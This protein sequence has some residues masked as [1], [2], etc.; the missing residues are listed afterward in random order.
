VTTE[1][2]TVLFTDMVGSTALASSLA[3]D[4]ADE[5]RR[6]HFAILRQAVAESG[7]IEV[8]HLGDGLMVVF[9]TA[10]A[11]LSCAVGMQQGVERDNRAREHLVGLRVGL[12][13]GEVIREDDDYFGDPVV[14]ASRLCARGES[15]QVL[16]ADVVRLMA[17]RRSRHECRVLGEVN[18][19]GLPVP[20]A[21]VE[22]V[23]EPLGAADAGTSVPLP[24][25]LAVRPAVGV[26]GRASEITVMLDA[27][28]R[29]ANGEGREV[30]LVSGEP[31]LG[32]STLVAEV[33][34]SGFDAGTCV[35][36][37]HCEEDL[38]SPYQLFGEALG[39]YV[40]H[41]AEDQLVAHV[42]AHGS[43]LVRLVPVLATRI[44]GLPPSMA[45]DADSERF[46]LFAAVVGIL[47]AASERQPVVL[48]LDDLQWADT[49]SLQL[50]RHLI[51][52]DL[53]MR[54]LILGAYR[55][56]ELSHSH[57]L[58]DTLAALHRQPAVTRIELAGLDDG[59]VVAFL[60]AAAGHVLD[61]AGLGLAHAVY[62]ETDGNPFFVSEVLRH[63][64]ETGAI[65]QDTAT[66]RWTALDTLD[67]MALPDSVRVVIDARVGRLGA[68]AGR[69]LSMAAVIGRDFDL[70]VL[71]R[72]TK[73]SEDALLDVLDAAAAAALVREFADSPGRYC[74]AHALIQH[75]LYE[76]LG[77]TRRSRAHRQ[78]AEALEDLV[79]DRP[80]RRIGE[81]ARH[82]FSATQPIDL[83]KAVGYSRQAA[84]A[85]LAALAP[86][87]AVH[88][89]AQ[90]LELLTQADDHDSVLVLDLAIGLGTAQRQTANPAYRDTLLDAAHLAER[91]GDTDRL[92]QAAL[93]N[94]RGW[95]SHTGRVDDERIAV[96]ERA[97]DAI[98]P[99]DSANRARL[100]AVLG[101]ELTFGVDLD[102]RRALSNEA[103][104]IARR[105]GDLPT[106]TWVLTH[107]FDSVRAPHLL[108]ERRSAAEENLAVANMLDDQMALWLAAQ[109]LTQITVEGG[110]FDALDHSLRLEIEL[111][112]ALR[113]PYPRW[114]TLVHQSSREFL[115]G[116]I[117]EADRLAADAFGLGQEIGQPD[118]LAIYAGTLFSIWVAQGRVADLV[119]LLEETSADNPGI[120]GLRAALATAYCGTNRMADAQAILT[121]TRQV[122]FA[123]INL[124]GVWLSTLWLFAAVAAELG[125][126]DAAQEL[127]DVLEP[128]ATQFASDGAHVQ[129]TVAQALGR[130]AAVLD[131]DDDADHWFGTAE[132]L[133]GN[134]K[135]VLMQ[136]GTRTYWAEALAR[137]ENTNDQRRARLLAERAR[138][139]ALEVGCTPIVER[140]TSVLS[141]T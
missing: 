79:G 9:A 124:D 1:N 126:R 86:E 110:D 70:E 105:L 50:L 21:T 40:T 119:P 115:A 91:L 8:K 33:A 85:A 15:G 81:L 22:V 31:G 114:L 34:R 136:A 3:P 48:V 130:L 47:A 127:F 140:S 66:G 94:S 125:D 109:G 12:S 19:K 52:S 6:D 17:G 129:G 7:G 63:L 102:R 84:D 139:T 67:Q 77:P 83:A 141:A 65:Y 42:A 118:A 49:A 57:P 132:A 30:L 64:S 137:H 46:L 56:S 28:K 29:V 71:A 135:A 58:L 82:W 96:L 120:L 2:V 45:T 108:A 106:L 41:V 43:E 37:G 35:L 11:A 138:Q 111:A 14:E 101:S 32:K 13:G 59:D 103:V 98:G 104:D 97:L 76:D 122:G 24:G 116:R 121:D 78:V 18:L 10:S 90:A 128:F 107:R 131:R 51:A 123:N 117:D 99:S 53:R 68:D 72:A 61:D 38:A 88:Y 27:F 87:V 16:A 5:L 133:D 69:V 25:R 26:V 36:F 55:A 62:R 60:E 54:V 89:F 73:T 112:D 113:Q 23:W 75:T 74:F 134:M 4:D 95:A 39:H 80:G 92:V 20:L 44:P 100:L 93:A